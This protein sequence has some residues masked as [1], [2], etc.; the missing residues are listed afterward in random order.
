[1]QEIVCAFDGLCLLDLTSQPSR[2]SQKVLLMHAS[3]CIPQ[4]LL[5]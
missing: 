3:H 5:C 4:E 2:H 1:M